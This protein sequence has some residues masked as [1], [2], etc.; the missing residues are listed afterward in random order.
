MM[1]KGEYTLINV[2]MYEESYRNVVDRM[3]HESDGPTQESRS[4]IHRVEENSRVKIVLHSPDI[5]LED[6]TETGIWRGKFLNFSFAFFLPE[7]YERQQIMFYAS[8]YVNDLI[9]TR[10]KFIVA[11]GYSKQ[12]IEVIRNDVLSAFMSYASQDRARVA[13][14]V[15]GMR[16][17]RP[18]M[19]IFFDVESL[20]SGD[21]WEPALYHEIENRDILFLC[22]SRYARESEWVGVE[23]RY[24]LKNKGEE[25]IE[26]I[27]I[28]PPDLCPPP[29]ELKH[30]HFNDKLLYIIRA[31]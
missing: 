14:V 7:Q 10:L 18:D 31:E 21:N 6:D 25:S 27:P 15:Q 26:P 28:D 29:K 30:K 12:K 19:D 11:C 24:A 16:K 9:A 13:A 5:I 2:V 8:I 23:W 22:W 20:R 1:L 3:I 4:G 17:A